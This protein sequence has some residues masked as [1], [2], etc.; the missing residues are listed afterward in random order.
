MSSYFP[1]VFVQN[2]FTVR[3][4]IIGLTEGKMQRKTNRLT[5]PGLD[6]TYK[7]YMIKIF[8]ASLYFS[9]AFFDTSSK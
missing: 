7:T 1:G 4:R 6:N 5:E 3:G 2:F 8:Q 9:S